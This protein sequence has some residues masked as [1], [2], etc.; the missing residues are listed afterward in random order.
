MKAG[1]RSG[2][3]LRNPNLAERTGFPFAFGV[4]LWVL[5]LLMA[6]VAEAQERARLPIT[7][8]GPA[9]RAGHYMAADDVEFLIDHL[10]GQPRMRFT[11]TDEVFYL[12]SEP[13][14]LGGRVLKHDTGEVALQVTGWGGVTLYTRKARAGL[15]AERIGDGPSLD[16][17]AVPARDTKI[18]AARLSQ[19]LADRHN[20]AVGF[21]TDW[22][23]LEREAGLRRIA[24][25]S[26]RNATYALEE[27]ASVRTTRANLRRVHVIRIIAGATSAATLQNEVLLV[28]F[29]A[30]RGAAARPS[31]LA[32]ANALQARLLAAGR[33]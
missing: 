20:L 19:R 15:P 3:L 31:S 17:K 13:A 22:G 18:F 24:L 10:G 11:H 6:P 28:S 33:R 4:L 16:P 14:A 9:P 2:P 25:D 23:L 29:A 30:Q 32:I 26:M 21:A 27:L 7:P 8:T 1:H 5:A 12:T